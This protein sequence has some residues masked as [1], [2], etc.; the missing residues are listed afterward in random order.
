MATATER[1]DAS[2]IGWTT[3]LEDGAGP[4][5]CG[6]AALDATGNRVALGPDSGSIG[7]T[8]FVTP[9]INVGAGPFSITLTHRYQFEGGTAGDPTL[10]DGGQIQISTDNGANWTS[11]GGAAYDGSINGASGNPM[12]GE[13]VFAGTSTGYPATM[14][15]TINLGT[16]YANSTVKLRFAIGTDGGAGAPGWELHTVALTGTNAPF[17]DLVP[18][19]L[20]CGE[21]V[22]GNG[23][24]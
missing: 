8:S 7:T 4:G 6:A 3:Q 19:T 9:S 14:V 16:T 20:P 22:F 10:W 24:E 17:T 11:I 1:F 18:E 15:D 21:A 5:S 2:N 12:E 13:P 23:F